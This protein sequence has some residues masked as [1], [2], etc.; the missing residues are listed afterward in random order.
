MNPVSS[1]RHKFII[2]AT[3]SFTK[4]VDPLKRASLAAFIK[5]NIICRFGIPDRLVSDNGTP[6]KKKEVAALCEKYGI[7][8]DRQLTIL[9]RMG[10]PKQL[11]SRGIWKDM[12]EHSIGLRNCLRLGSLQKDGHR[13]KAVYLGL[14]DR[15]NHTDA[16]TQAARV[17]LKYRIGDEKMNQ[18]RRAT[19]APPIR[20]SFHRTQM[21]LELHE[22]MTSVFESENARWESSLFRL[23]YLAVHPAGKFAP[24]WEGKAL[25]G[26][27][28]K[29]P[30]LDGKISTTRS[31]QV[32]RKAFPEHTSR[33][34]QL[35]ISDPFLHHFEFITHGPLLGH[36][37]S[38][39]TR[40]LPQRLCFLRRSRLLLQSTYLLGSMVSRFIIDVD[41]F[42]AMAFST[43]SILPVLDFQYDN[44]SIAFDGMPSQSAASLP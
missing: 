43:G 24:N 44:T 39:S 38:Q 12:I 3:E 6:F 35:Q 29:P 10:K 13:R 40:R 33:S 23:D 20:R 1:K 9:K 21:Y 7:K 15:R 27:F 28:L 34:V 36:R 26:Y 2:A 37:P 14:R 17:A 19:Y 42:P 25:I 18:T 31:Y 41:A 30:L 16:I 32:L 8:Q 4:W 5:E 22:P 11:T